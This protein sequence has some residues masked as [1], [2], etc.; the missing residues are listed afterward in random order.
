MEKFVIYRDT[1]SSQENMLNILAKTNENKHINKYDNLNRLV[2]KE[3]KTDTKTFNQSYTYDKTRVTSFT[4]FNTTYNYQYD[5][6]GNVIN[7]NGSTYTYD[8]YGRLLTSNYN[9]KNKYTYDNNGNLSKIE[10][11]DSNENVLSTTVYNRTIS[12]SYKL[13]SVTGDINAT[14]SY[15]SGFNPTNITINGVS[16]KITYKG[17]RIKQF[18][19]SHYLYNDKGIRIAKIVY[20]YEG[21]TMIGYER[22]YYELEGSKILSEIIF[23]ING[24]KSRLDYNYDI[25]GELVSVEYLGYK[26]FYIKY[27][28][29]NINYVVDENGSIMIKYSYDEWGVPTKTIVQPSCPIGVLNPFMYKSYYFDND[30]E[31]YYL[32]SRFYHPSLRRFITMDDVNYLDKLNV[33]NLNLYNYSKNNPIMYYDPSGHSPYI[34]IKIVRA[35]GTIA[36]MAVVALSISINNSRKT[37]ENNTESIGI[38]SADDIIFGEDKNIYYKENDTNVKIGEIDSNGEYIITDSYKYTRE[39]MLIICEAI[40]NHYGGTQED[41]D[42]MFDEWE[43]HNYG[44][45]FAKNTLIG[46]GVNF[47]YELFVGED[48]GLDDS[49][50]EV[51]F[52]Q[53]PETGFRKFVLDVL[54]FFGN[55]FA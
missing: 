55:L 26:Y 51:N 54:N 19:N 37:Y 52:G 12:N 21:S 9:E 14:L 2:A 47:I 27:A 45:Y 28:L 24:N 11:L 49:C 41:V 35:L 8:K 36:L 18:G 10:R 20:K 31:M 50:K 16:R 30:T 25:N 48:D 33:S 3:I 6:M 22:H 39:E 34:T 17:K 40:V 53:N 5:E 32:N 43:S 13:T 46:K 4:T 1:V 7:A 15:G 29:G 42:R 38:D 44:Y 23:D